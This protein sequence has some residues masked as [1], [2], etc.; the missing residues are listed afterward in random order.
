MS[1][2]RQT[3]GPV[4]HDDGTTTFRFW[5]PALK[6]VGLVVGDRSP[7]PMERKGDGFFELRCDAQAGDSYSFEIGN[8]LKIP[9]P[10]SRFQPNGVHS[11]SRL[12]D[13]TQPI[14]PAGS[15]QGRE[16]S[17]L[18]IYELH[19]GAFTEKGTYQSA[20]ERLPELVDLG[21]TAIELMPL[22]QAAGRWNWGY[23]GVNLYAPN[24]A[25]GSPKD[26]RD[27]VETAHRLGL[28][29][30]L[31]IVYNHFGPEGNYLGLLGGYISKSHRT[32]WGDAPNFDGKN[33]DVLRRFILENID[34]WIGTFDLDGIRLDATHCIADESDLH[35]VQKI[36]ERCRSWE[37]ELERPIHLIAESNVYDPELLVPLKAE[38]FGFDALWC[39]DFIHSVYAAL[40]PGEHLSDRKYEPG[41]DLDLILRRG[42]VFHGTLRTARERHL[43]KKYP[44][45]VGMES[46]VAAIQNHDFIGNHPAGLRMHQTTSPDAQR[47]S[48]AL[49][50]LSPSIPMLF[51]GEEFASEAPFYFF[52]DFEDQKIRRAVKRG[53]KAEHPQH[54][55]GNAVSPLSD[56]AF[57][58]SKIG[59]T[60]DNDMLGWYRTLIGI[61]N[62]WR[63]SDHLSSVNLAAE[64]DAETST[65]I[66]R[67]SP[68]H[69]EN[70][71]FVVVRLHPVNAELE[72]LLLKIE[73]ECLLQQNFDRVTRVLTG[74]GVVAGNGNC[75]IL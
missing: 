65:G 73:G 72:P 5:A 1:K 43:L 61:R 26:L 40:A 52:T 66:L 54:D 11:P 14:V 28:A 63:S 60:A 45:K 46:I 6:E 33:A 64:W 15:W 9:D 19:V 50:L 4:I 7:L 16:K 55:W 49:L 13:I 59:E 32:P 34:Y 67:Y 58:D 24:H 62:D 10:A 30:I 69:E 27:F 25:Y 18:I 20:V 21:I 47:A 48:A 70:E 53:R 29:V 2:T 12:V 37:K 39:D 68:G 71:R 41:S 57:L 36:G 51:M 8:G 3:F 56:D 38:G 35:I 75:R 44:E 17:D 23:D 22:A 42:Y 31:D 74:F